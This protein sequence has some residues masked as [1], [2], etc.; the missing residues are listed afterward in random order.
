MNEYA[1]CSTHDIVFKSNII[2]PL[3]T[4][5]VLLL[6]YK[7]SKMINYLN[8]LQVVM[9]ATE[10]HNLAISC[11]LLH[12]KKNMFQSYILNY[13]PLQFTSKPI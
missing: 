12:L 8:I 2:S 9:L 13:F 11:M 5:S 10:L 1:T 6:V 3:V 7:N 4:L